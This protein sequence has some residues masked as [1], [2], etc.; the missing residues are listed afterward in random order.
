VKSLL[1]PAAVEYAL[2]RGCVKRFFTALRAELCFDRHVILTISLREIVKMTWL[3]KKY[4]A[5]E[6]GKRRN[7]FF[8][9]I[10]LQ[11]QQL[12]LSMYSI[13]GA[14]RRA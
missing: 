9:T 5:A 4:S 3:S 1:P 2:L 8:L 14:L 6:G 12:A 7:L 11:L 10:L 13:Y